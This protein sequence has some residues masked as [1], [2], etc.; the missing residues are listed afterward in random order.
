MEFY[1]PA[2]P[3]TEPFLRD[4]LCELGFSGVRLNQ[5]GIPFRGEWEDAWRA[6]LHSR[7]AQRIQALLTV[8][9]AASPEELY[10]G[11]RAFDWTPFL[12]PRQTFVVSAFCRSSIF[13]HSGFTAL[14]IKDAVVDQIRDRYGSRPD[15]DKNDP[16]VRI[17]VYVSGTRVKVYLDVSG[18]PLYRRGYR[19]EAGEA[20]LRET[21]AAA[22]LRAS[23]WDRSSRLA[24]PLCGSG[25][26]AI[27][28][29]LWAGNVAPGIFRE[30]FGFER[31]D[32]FDA[33]VAETMKQLRGEARA[34]ARGGRPPKII[35]ADVDA[36]VLEVAGRNAGSA[37]VRLTF[38]Q[39]DIG[40]LQ[41]GDAVGV[42]VTNPPYGE[43]L[44]TDRETFRKLGAAFSRMHGKR[45][46]V[47]SGN[48]ELNSCIPVAPLQRFPLK[49]GNLDCECLL[50]DIP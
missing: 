12:S 48:P 16:D 31:W 24:D 39:A 4:E 40:D 26:I 10:A 3:G 35:A 36:A 6:C 19:R 11:V 41:L 7:I 22:L 46:C 33:A 42:V 43:R 45:L 27:E 32:C 30:R 21:L 25:T 8:F 14:K 34:L 29:A 49:N 20:P 5:G 1:A 2:S 23:G 13:S 18:E 9:P 47:L 37:G 50:Y 15:V 17:F 44:R 28:A 38:R